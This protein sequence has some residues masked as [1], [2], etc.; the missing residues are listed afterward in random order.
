[1]PPINTDGYET[2]RLGRVQAQA[3]QVTDIAR[4]NIR[5]SVAN[6]ESMQDLE[7]KSEELHASSNQFRVGA[8]RVR[9]MMCCRSYKMLAL[10]TLGVVIL[11]VIIIAPIAS[12]LSK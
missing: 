5:R 8:S 3:D 10:T 2:D 4:D 7:M 1:M 9:R 6:V 12:T 11:L